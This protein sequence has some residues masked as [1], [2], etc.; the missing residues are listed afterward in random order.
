MK[1]NDLNPVLSRCLWIC[2]EMTHP[3][4]S[5]DRVYSSGLSRALA[6]SGVN[7]KFVAHEGENRQRDPDGAPVDFVGV[8]GGTFNDYWIAVSSPLPVTAGIQATA[9]FRR[10]LKQILETE[11]FDCI[12]LDQLGSGWALQPVRDWVASQ[13]K[14]KQPLIIYLAHNHETAVWAGMARESQRG[15]LRNLMVRRNADKVARLESRLVRE[16]NLVLTITEEDANAFSAMGAAIQPTVL[17]PGFSGPRAPVRQ[18]G[19]DT[20]RRIVMVGSFKWAPKEENLRQFLKVADQAFKNANIHFDVIGKVPDSLRAALEPGLQAT[21]LHGFVEDV[22]PLF[23][24]ARM[25]VIPELIGGGF[26]LKLL[27]YLFGRL[28]M[29]SIRAAAAG[30]PAEIREQMIL[31]DDL[32][33]LVA[34]IIENIDRTEQLN[35]MQQRGFELAEAAYGWE[36]R[37]L[38][39][40]AAIESAMNIVSA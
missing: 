29:A 12:V 27:D 40:K 2:R 20:P 21:T 22:E 8:D 6:R 18:I 1:M 14:D 9:A 23:S 15:P 35:K 28:P 30:M 31:A 17:T 7:V 16:S 36:E 34:A 5:G 24:N 32:E 10:Q 33:S 3:L 39:M 11:S 26:K 19:A 4:V 37:G 25:A 13:P 38:E